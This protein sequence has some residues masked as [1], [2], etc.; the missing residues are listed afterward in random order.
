MNETFNTWRVRGSTH[1]HAVILIVLGI[2]VLLG[3]TLIKTTQTTNIYPAQSQQEA[4]LCID[5]SAECAIN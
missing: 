3:A 5:Y 1:S 2:L 4:A